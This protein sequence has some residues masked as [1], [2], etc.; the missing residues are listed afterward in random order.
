MLWWNAQWRLKI[1]LANVTSGYAAINL[2]GPRARDLLVAAG[3]DSDVTPAGFPYLGVRAATI[4]GIPARLL[5]IGFAGELGY[6]IHVP[7]SM[8]EAL[9]DVMTAAGQPFGLVAV[10][11]EAQRTLRLE[12][13]HIIV[14]QDTDGLSTPDEAGMEWAVAKKPFFVGKR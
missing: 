9:W 6:E 13:G 2:V 5:R 12:K 1:D 3:I 10:G 7:S 14:G 8:G 4:A 11:I